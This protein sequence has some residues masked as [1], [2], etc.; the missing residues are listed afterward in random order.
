MKNKEWKV[1][2]YRIEDGEWIFECELMK[3]EYEDTIRQWYL[4][5][6]DIYYGG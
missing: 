2:I 5:Q 3:K 1:G 6:H 4:S